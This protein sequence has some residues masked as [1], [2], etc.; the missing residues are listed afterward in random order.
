MVNYVEGRRIQEDILITIGCTGSWQK[1]A[2]PGEPYVETVEKAPEQIF[3]YDARK[4]GFTIRPTIEDL[5][6]GHSRM[7]PEKGVKNVKG[8]FSTVSSLV[9]DQEAI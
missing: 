3:L 4:S 7:T 6:P 1:A 8:T 5:V 2:T 9:M